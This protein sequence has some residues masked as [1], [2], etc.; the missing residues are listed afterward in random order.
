MASEKDYTPQMNARLEQSFREADQAREDLTDSMA[1]SV[2]ANCDLLH[3]GLISAK[4][5][6]VTTEMYR[7]LLGNLLRHP[8][9]EVRTQTLMLFNE[10]MEE[11]W[12]RL[13]GSGTGKSQS[14]ANGN[15]QNSH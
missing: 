1:N 14:M 12:P 7:H 13:Q 4:G 3:H 15:G 6:E 10:A 2:A 5:L 8:S 11:F 9:G